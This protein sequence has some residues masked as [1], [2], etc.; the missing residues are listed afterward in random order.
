MEQAKAKQ[1]IEVSVLNQSFSIETD[2]NPDHV[3]R[4][5]NYVDKKVKEIQS[6]TVKASSLHIALLTCLNIA[7]ELLRQKRSDKSAVKNAEKK[8]DEILELLDLQL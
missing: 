2:A 3:D 4:V 5:A 8:I 6:Q 1:L 7:D